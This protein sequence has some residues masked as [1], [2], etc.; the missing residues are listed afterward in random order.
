MTNTSFQYVI[1]DTF[2]APG[3]V[4]WNVA[5]SL[6]DSYLY[7]HV[8]ITGG[9]RYL[10][11]FCVGKYNTPIYNMVS[12]DTINFTCP[13]DM[14]INTYSISYTDDVSW[15]NDP[16]QTWT[17]N[18]NTATMYLSHQGLYAPLADAIGKYIVITLNTTTTV[19]TFKDGVKTVTE[20]PGQVT[21]LAR[22]F[23]NVGS[24]FRTTI[25]YNSQYAAKLGKCCAGDYTV[26]IERANKGTPF[27]GTGYT[28]PTYTRT[29]DKTN[30]TITHTLTY[31]YEK[32]YNDKLIQYPTK[33]YIHND[34]A[35]YA[36]Y[37][38]PRVTID[39]GMVEHQNDTDFVERG[40]YIG[41]CVHLTAHKHIGYNTQTT[42]TVKYADLDNPNVETT[43]GTAETANTEVNEDYW[44]YFP[45]QLDS[46]KDWQVKA[47]LADEI[48]T[49]T[50]ITTVLC[51]KPTM[52]LRYEKGIAFLKGST[53]PNAL[54]IGA[55]A[56][57]NN[58][59]AIAQ[60]IV[61]MLV[62]EDGIMIFLRSD[63]SQYVPGYVIE[64][65][66]ERGAFNLLADTLTN[67]RWD[68]WENGIAICFKNTSQSALWEDDGLTCVSPSSQSGYATETWLRSR[69]VCTQAIEFFWHGTYD[70]RNNP[71]YKYV[72]VETTRFNMRQF[73][74]YDDISNMYIANAY[75]KPNAKTGYT[76]QDTFSEVGFYSADNSKIR[77]YAS[78]TKAVADPAMVTNDAGYS[79]VADITLTVS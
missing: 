40:D 63:S 62:E 61:G 38:A 68:M 18:S 23:Y 71:T 36:E 3:T 26:Q 15:R 41:V 45:S 19:T 47:I 49:Q 73:Y 53:R 22:M 37:Y 28:Q 5:L 39:A 21:I 13:A 56:Y 55:D 33:K 2:D 20:Y 35:D 9:V 31:D 76:R 32:S 58:I 27:Y 59:P 30:A 69:G 25:T 17:I 44:Y 34:T 6:S 77:K 16:I 66:T 1:T 64:I 51:Y 60:S 14:I 7:P 78:N 67:G 70:E 12:G 50:T 4:V 57:F 65:R 75:T 8:D 42:I 29:I 52:S 74:Y 10:P 24:T 79:A 11:V 43:L 46:D 54:E 48:T 72:N